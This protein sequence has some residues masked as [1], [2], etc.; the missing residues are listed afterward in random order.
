MPAAK[1]WA[2]R[3]EPRNISIGGPVPPWNTMEYLHYASRNDVSHRSHCGTFGSNSRG[4]DLVMVNL[5][6]LNLPWS[7]MESLACPTQLNPTCMISGGFCPSLNL[8]A[9]QKKSSQERSCDPV[10]GMTWSHACCTRKKK[11]QQTLRTLKLAGAKSL[12]WQDVIM[13]VATKVGTPDAT[14]N[15]C[16]RDILI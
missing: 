13:L 12:M 16:H 11:K 3:W 1:V 10:F 8:G 14:L 9:E 2:R 6:N 4:T 7:S 15:V 5:V